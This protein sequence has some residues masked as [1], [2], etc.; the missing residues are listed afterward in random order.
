MTLAETRDQ[1]GNLTGAAEWRQGSLPP[2]GL[3]RSP[4]SRDK[5]KS[6]AMGRSSTRPRPCIGRASRL[7]RD[8]PGGA[9]LPMQQGVRC[10]SCRLVRVA[11]IAR[12]RDFQAVGPIRVDEVEG[13]TADVHVRD[14]LFDLRHMA[15]NTL[16]S[17]AA[18]HVVRVLFD[19]RRVRAILR[20]RPMA[21]QTYA[22]GGLPQHEPALLFVLI[23][24]G[25][26]AVE[27]GA[28]LLLVG[29]LHP[30]FKRSIEYRCN[31]RTRCLLMRFGS[32]VPPRTAGGS[33]PRSHRLRRG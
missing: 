27:A 31:T 1:T 29:T 13:V 10:P 14:R 19:R 15:G 26:M 24:P 5:A 3:Q 17:R 4:I 33:C 30:M 7:I 11:D 6:R 2:V 25:E 20:V 28:L 9:V 12:V 23:F 18:R 21:G 22:A 16:T 8:A 32:R